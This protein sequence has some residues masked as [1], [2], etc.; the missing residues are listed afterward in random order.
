MGVDRLFCP[1]PCSGF[2][3]GPW[4][5]EAAGLMPETAVQHQSFAA[6]AAGVIQELGAGQCKC[7][8]VGKALIFF[9]APSATRAVPAR[10]RVIRVVGDQFVEVHDG[11]CKRAPHTE[12][13]SEEKR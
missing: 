9:I 5:R 10:G 3:S 7:I 8:D 2:S 11:R 1:L 12:R 4:V 6:R 13:L